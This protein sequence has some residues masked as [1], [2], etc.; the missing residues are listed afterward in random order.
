MAMKQYIKKNWIILSIG[1]I[2]LIAI[3]F[4]VNH[5]INHINGTTKAQIEARERANAAADQTMQELE[6]QGQWYQEMMSEPV[7]VTNSEGETV[8]YTIQTGNC[9]NSN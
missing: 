8:T 1:A 5:F 7:T 4:A 9:I 2:I 3:S 6:K